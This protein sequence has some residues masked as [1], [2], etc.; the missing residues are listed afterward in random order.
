MLYH[1]GEFLKHY[2]FPFNVFQYISFR[3]FLA[4][5]F[6]FFLGLILFK[7]YERFLKPKYE[8]IGGV[9]REYASDQEVKKFTPSMAG[10]VI[11]SLLVVAAFL[12]LR[13]DK[14]YPYLAVLVL[15]L[16]GGI[17]LLDDLLKFVGNAIH[18]GR[19][20]ENTLPRWFE[21]WAKTHKGLTAKQKLFFQFLGG[22]IVA[23]LMVELLPI[24][25]K[26][27]PPL[28]KDLSVDLGSFYVL[29]AA[30][31]IAFFSN[32][33]NITDGLDGLAIG[34][35]LS[36]AVVLGFVAYLAG[37]YIYADYLK[38]PYVPYAGEL[39]VLTMAF[40][41]A[42]LSFLWYNAYPARLFMGDTGSLAIGAFL[43][44]LAL[45]VK[46]E[47]I[48]LVAGGVFVVEA[49]SSLIQ[50]AVCKLTKGKRVVEVEDPKTGQKILKRDC[51]RVFPIAPLHE[52][53]KRKDLEENHIVVR[54][55][56]VS[57]LL[58]VAS[59]MFLK[60]R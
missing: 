21:K 2:W 49:I 43:A 26:V 10:V 31:F 50:I 46:A 20:R 32:A 12:L 52:T 17:G 59:L 47:F 35:S 22:L 54:F 57:T 1:L 19:W 8:A 6:T 55:W 44:F 29:Y 15:L 37:N 30:L 9:K 7:L 38:I 14:P 16:F 40:L 33:V 11:V 4:V 18:R 3:S 48:L 27:Y 5:L 24:D 53:F 60:L 51:I 39:T 56:I 36:T 45:A 13:L 58:G 41:G 42:G 34:P 28:F 23:T 25:T